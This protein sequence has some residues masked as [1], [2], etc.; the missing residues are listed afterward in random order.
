M[1]QAAVA[2]NWSLQDI[3]TLFN[4]GLAPESVDEIVFEGGQHFYRPVF[5]KSYTPHPLRKKLFINNNSS[6]PLT[7]EAGIGIFKIAM[8]DYADNIK[9]QF[10]IR[11][12]LNN[13]SFGD[14]ARQS[15]KKYLA[16]FD[17]RDS[18]IV[19]EIEG[20]FV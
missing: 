1:S 15:I 16:M 14:S 20:A 11:S 10:G 5:E 3:S 4:Q 8:Q 19:E 6:S 2:D 13:L 18:E 12:T 17:E 9:N 7:M